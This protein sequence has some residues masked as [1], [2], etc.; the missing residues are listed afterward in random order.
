[1]MKTREPRARPRWSRRAKVGLSDEELASLRRERR[2]PSGPH[3]QHLPAALLSEG[4]ALFN[5]GYDDGYGSACSCGRCHARAGRTARKEPTAAALR[6]PL[7]SVLNQFPGS[8]L[9][10]QQ[11]VDFVCNG[12]E[13]ASHYG[14]NGQGTGRMPGAVTPPYKINAENGEVDIEPKDAG[15]P[16]QGAMMTQESGPSS[17]RTEPRP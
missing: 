5:M 9:G 3:R 17:V 12:S 10:P 16:D 7:T 13:R 1:M 2:A 11:Q 8:S 4:E 15:T 6:A 14:Q